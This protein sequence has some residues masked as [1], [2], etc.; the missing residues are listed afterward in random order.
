MF[1]L[2]TFFIINDG[3]DLISFSLF[4][5]SYFSKLMTFFSTPSLL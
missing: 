1:N 3:F 2:F 5:I 4:Y